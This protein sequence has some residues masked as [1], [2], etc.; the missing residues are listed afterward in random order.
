MDQMTVKSVV[1][2]LWKVNCNQ[3]KWMLHVNTVLKKKQEKTLRKSGIKCCCKI[4]I[5][6]KQMQ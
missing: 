5:L 4:W 2:I 1:G 3:E 6:L